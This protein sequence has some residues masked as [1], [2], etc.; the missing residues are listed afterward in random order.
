MSELQ[1]SSGGVVG[2]RL[3]MEDLWEER[4]HC[5]GLGAVNTDFL[6]EIR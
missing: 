6:P 1:E 2:M 4:T 5:E 3:A